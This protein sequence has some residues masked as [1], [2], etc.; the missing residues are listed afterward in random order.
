MNRDE[1]VYCVYKH[2]TP[3]GKVYI[4]VTMNPKRRFSRNGTCYKGCAVFYNA[5]L[6][7]K[8]VNITHEILETGLTA[9][10]ADE[11]EAYYI[12]EYKST[13]KKHGYNILPSGN[14]STNG[15]TEE[16]RAKM[17]ATRKGRLGAVW[18]DDMRERLSEKKKGCK[19]FTPSEE[20]RKKISS[21]LTGRPCSEQTRK[22]ISESQKGWKHTEE[23]LRKMSLAHVGRIISDETRAKM[24]KTQKE[25]S[26]TRRAL[27]EPR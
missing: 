15:I 1:N 11:R 2:T 19:G 5:I 3:G 18:T 7:Y 12:A 17:S 27:N 16:M 22:K 9:Q 8:W 26:A 20:T 13:E 23:Q 25:R 24:S 14:V 4:G 6:K 21:A 10:Q